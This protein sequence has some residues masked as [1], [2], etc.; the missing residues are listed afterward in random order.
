[1]ELGCPVTRKGGVFLIYGFRGPENL[2][3]LPVYYSVYLLG[4]I[5]GNRIVT[6][7]FSPE[8]M[9]TTIEQGFSPRLI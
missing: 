5:R 7:G 4:K 3:E 1:M 8:A 6:P 2:V 9:N